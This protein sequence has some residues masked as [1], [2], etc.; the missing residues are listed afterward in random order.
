MTSEAIVQKNLYTKI[1]YFLVDFDYN[2][3]SYYNQ[4]LYKYFNTGGPKVQKNPLAILES[5]YVPP[6]DL[7]IHSKNWLIHALNT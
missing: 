2:D 4:H 5:E 1:I 7:E 3:Q 6:W